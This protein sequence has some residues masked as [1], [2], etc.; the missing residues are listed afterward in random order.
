M[1]LDWVRLGI[2]RGPA[3]PV[4][5]PSFVDRA[6]PDIFGNPTV[7]A[8]IT[9]HLK[10]GRL[11]HIPNAMN[12]DFAERA[13]KML[14]ASR[15]W[16]I[17]EDYRPF[18]NFKYH[19]LHLRDGIPDDLKECLTVFKSARTR[20]FIEQISGRDCKGDAE[21]GASWFFPGD[22]Q[23]PHT[24]A[25]RGGSTAYIWHLTKD[26]NPSW[27]GS[28]VWCQTGTSVLPRFNSL[29]IFNVTEH[30]LHFVEPV[31]GIAQGKRLAIFGWWT[32]G[33]D[34]KTGVKAEPAEMTMRHA[35]YGP[36]RLR[37]EGREDIVVL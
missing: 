22:Y 29:T 36:P 7:L 12:A 30:S 33:A 21:F 17:L 32:K 5:G 23:L 11:V 26:W 15:S 16:Q 34:D 31:A 35:G 4:V 10:A 37:V 1:I 25:Q 8:Q 27:G 14:D 6:N 20:E 24:D 9:T 2:L 13:H 19:A 28:F 3:V 18:Y